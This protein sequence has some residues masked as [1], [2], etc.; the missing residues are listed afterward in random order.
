MQAAFKPVRLETGFLKYIAVRQEIDAGTGLPRLSNHREKSVLQLDDRT[1]LFI[2][3]VIDAA[4]PVNLKVHMGRQ[5]INYGGTHT[6]KSSAG[7]I[8][9]VIEFTAC[10]KGGQYDSGC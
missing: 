1:S 4:V 7:L 8:S 9:V 3:I 10:M 2:F 5:G 6:V